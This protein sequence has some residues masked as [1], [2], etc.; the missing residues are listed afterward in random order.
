[1]PESLQFSIHVP[2]AH[3]ATLWSALEK[4]EE[5]DSVHVAIAKDRRSFIAHNKDGSVLKCEVKGE[6]VLF[7]V[8]E[9]PNGWTVKQFQ[10]KV[11]ER[12]EEL[13]AIKA[14]G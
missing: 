4:I 13:L 5:E 1:M 6:R 9:N 12:K 14:K 8:L 7:D 3:H 10:D 2:H 11:L